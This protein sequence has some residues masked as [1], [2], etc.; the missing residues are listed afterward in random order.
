MDIAH[1]LPEAFMSYVSSGTKD[2]DEITKRV[3]KTL[4]RY[5]SSDARHKWITIAKRDKK[6]AFENEFFTEAEKQEIRKTG[7]EPYP[8]NKLVGG[9]QGMS[10]IATSNRPDIKVLPLRE[11]DPYLAELA[12]VGLEHVWLKNYGNDVTYDM[13]EERNVSGIGCVEGRLDRN[14]GPFGAVTFEES[15]ATIWYWD[16]ESKRRD[17]SDTH[18]IKAQLRT[19]EY[20]E[21]VYNL[22]PDKVASID[23]DYPD[24]ERQDTVTAGDN[25]KIKPSHKAPDPTTPRKVWEI[26]AYMKRTEKEHWAVAVV[27]GNPVL[28]DFPDVKSEKAALAEI[29]RIRIEGIPMEKGQPNAPVDD[30]TYWPRTL[31][32]RY[33]TIIVGTDIVEQKDGRGG[34]AK[35][36]KNPYGLDSDGDPVLPVIFYYGQRT[37]KAYYRSPTF[38]AFGPN[39]SLCKREAQYTLAISKNLSS[40]PMRDEHGTRW[41][42]PSRPDAPG[43][44]LLL[45]KSA[46]VPTRLQTGNIDFAA[47]SHRLAEDKTDIFEAYGLNE[48]MRGKV[49]EG[50]ERMSGRLGL[51]LQDTATIMQSPAIRGLESALERLGKLLLSIMLRHWPREKWEALVT[52]DRINEF[53]PVEDRMIN[54]EPDNDKSDELIAQEMEI[55][56]RKWEGAIDKITVDGITIVDFNIAVTAGSSLPTNRLLKQETALEYYKLGLYDRQAALAYSGEPHAKEIAKRIDQKEMQMAQAGVKMRKG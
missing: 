36:L 41:A 50:L 45:S 21:S 2:V 13:V 30:V 53:R 40:P 32:N 33:L 5:A 8:V 42:D 27:R 29:E 10:A 9:I 17:R 38:Y 52:E 11:S 14:K 46:R 22:D 26:E 51:T 15:D 23:D 25:Y 48:V 18:L 44:E 12:K 7:A 20:I 31:T 49:P 37:R 3:Y 19:M 28:V 24:G 34:K 1:I 43:N 55:R 39:K 6:A 4:F 54:Q 16:A 47:L 35:E 56:K